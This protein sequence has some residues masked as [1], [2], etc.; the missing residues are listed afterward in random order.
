LECRVG[1][2]NLQIVDRADGEAELSPVCTNLESGLG[3]RSV[4]HVCDLTTEE[5]PMHDGVTNPNVKT[6]EAHT[7]SIATNQSALTDDNGNH[8][9]YDGVT[10]ATNQNNANEGPNDGSNGGEHHGHT[11][12]DN[13]HNTT[14]SSSSHD[15]P[16]PKVSR[17][18]R[19][20]DADFPVPPAKGKIGG[21]TSLT[22]YMPH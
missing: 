15:T 12:V 9:E 16:A 7:S 18:N 6:L 3:K 1:C 10:G 22:K 5:T 20:G 11:G 13:Q 8:N 2:K 21:A 4:S 17:G 19:F 14:S